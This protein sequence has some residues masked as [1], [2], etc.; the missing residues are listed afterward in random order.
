MGL[1]V[2]DKYIQAARFQPGEKIVGI[3]SVFSDVDDDDMERLSDLVHAQFKADARKS[4]VNDLLLVKALR[5]GWMER[6]KPLKACIGAPPLGTLWVV[7]RY[8]A[9]DAGFDLAFDR[10]LAAT[11]G[12]DEWS[13]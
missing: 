5:C 7:Y 8:K 4:F 11:G 9:L 6:P 10:A 1:H 12:V 2:P 3:N 13:F